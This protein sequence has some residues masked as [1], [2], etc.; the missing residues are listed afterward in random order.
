MRI[1]AG[2]HRSRKLQSLDGATTR[3]TSDKVKEAIFSS[4]GP[5]FD[6][7]VIL[8]LFGGSG[9]IALEALSRGMEYAYIGEQDK[10]AIQI[11]KENIKSLQEEHH[12][13]V[14]PYGY[15]EVLR[16]LQDMKFDLVF[17]DPPYALEVYEE[18]L[19]YLLSHAMLNA[20]SMVI[21]ETKADYQFKDNYG[22]LK[23]KKEKRYGIS[24]V[25]YF[26]GE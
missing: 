23:L 18:I 26:R 13:K 17:L 7:G 25:T 22:F 20:H 5:Y 3:P 12:T 15:D 4:I 11:I 24:K 9:G 16:Q 19:D 1:T 6:G 2:K 10:R 21:I 8:D 14:M